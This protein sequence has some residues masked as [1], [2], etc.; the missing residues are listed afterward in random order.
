MKTLLIT[1]TTIAMLHIFHSSSQLH[2]MSPT[3]K[4]PNKINLASKSWHRYCLQIWMIFPLLCQVWPFQSADQHCHFKKNFEKDDDDD[5]DD[6][7]CQLRAYCI[8][9][10]ISIISLLSNSFEICGMNVTLFPFT[11]EITEAENRINC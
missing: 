9:F 3:E 4:I 6:E 10:Y 8:T 2:L 5:D 11:D 7:N 1:I